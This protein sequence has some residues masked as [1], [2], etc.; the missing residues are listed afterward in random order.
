L[1]GG[2]SWSLMR[3]DVVVGIER[4]EKWGLGFEGGASG[5][6]SPKKEKGKNDSAFYTCI[7]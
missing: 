1:N 5:V 6:L 3:V 2:S 4:G 7:G